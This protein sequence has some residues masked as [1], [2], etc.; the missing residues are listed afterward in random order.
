MK[1]VNKKL[2][3]SQIATICLLIISILL[4]VAYFVV[5]GIA[6]NRAK[7]NT[8]T[9]AS[10][11]Q[12]AIRED[13]GESLYLNRPIAYPRVQESE[14]ILIEI[15]KD[16][17]GYGVSRYPDDNGNF[18][19]H[20]FDGDKEERYPFLPPIAGIEGDFNYE[21]LYA[22]EQNDG[23]G[24]IPHLTYLC[25]ALGAPY[26]TER[27][28]LPEEGTDEYNALLRE[29]GLTSSESTQIVFAYGKRDPATN[30]I[31][32]DTRDS[33][34]ITI[35]GKAVSGAGYYFMVNDGKHDRN[36]IYYTSSE[37]FTYALGGFASFVN[38]R[39][40][41]E[42]LSNDKGFSPYLTTDFKSWTGSLF[43]TDGDVID[44]SKHKDPTIVA[45][46][47]AYIT[48][49]KSQDK[50]TGYNGYDYE[51]DAVLAFDLEALSDVMNATEFKKLKDAFDGVKVGSQAEKIL[52]TLISDL[53]GTSNKYV[54]FTKDENGDVQPVEYKYSISKIESV[55]TTKD[56]KTIEIKD[57]AVQSYHKQLK[58]TYTYTGG[59]KES[60]HEQ[61]AV[62]NINDLP[63]TQRSK[64]VGLD[65][66][67]TLATPVEIT[68]EYTK[69]NALKSNETYYLHQVY[70]VFDENGAVADV[71]TEKS[72]ISYSYVVSVDGNIDVNELNEKDIKTGIVRLCDLKEGDL[73]Y[74]LISLLLN[75]KSEE[76]SEIKDRVVYSKDY[77][78]EFM[79]E[80]SC[81]EISDVEYFVT[82]EIIVSFEFVN[83]SERDPFYGD[84]FFK[85]TLEGEYGMY[86][87]NAGTCEQ[88][89][90]LLGGVGA[91]GS[92]SSG[93][94]GQTVAVGLTPEN[95]YK[96]GLF[97][98][99]VY[100]EM[101][102]G[103]F[104]K[105][106]A[107]GNVE[108]SDDLSDFGW[109]RTVG[110]TLYI[111]D[112]KYDEN[113][114]KYRYIG[115]D[116]YDII[117]R[118]ESDDFD[119]VEYGFVEFWARRSMVMMDVNKLEELKLEFNMKDLKGEY[120]F[121]VSYEEKYEKYVN[122]KYYVSST[123]QEGYSPIQQ[124]II[125]V[126]AGDGAFETEFTK[127]FG[128]G[129]SASL[130]KLYDNT[131][132][133]GKVSYHPGSKLTLGAGYFNSVYQSLLL[134]NYLD[135][136][137]DRIARPGDE[138][139]TSPKIFSM[140]LKVSGKGYYY[141]YDFYRVDARRVMVALYRTDANGNELTNDPVTGEKLGKVSDFYITWGAFQNLA[142]NYITLLNGQPID[143]NAGYYN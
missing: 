5:S 92:N 31:I 109:L 129:V 102:R 128:R 83:A 57:G 78:Y 76:L 59:G 75:K 35:G 103:L 80:F 132:G 62:I 49:Q 65:I 101:P 18:V 2:N 86:G 63:E 47:D 136:F 105:T 50:A 111:S 108:S 54:E 94:T 3:K 12:I 42:G 107:E 134:T 133:G 139:F 60:Y 66:G 121:N 67:E 106:E 23:F 40:V 46:G 44:Y 38:G 141:T 87:L 96:Y 11:T 89:V 52:L 64:F 71:I 33:Y 26:F 72:Y 99:K 7:N 135:C 70:A 114:T 4:T 21:S 37:Y 137:E 61:H 51:K 130:A 122:G 1:A 90:E 34:V 74:S 77:Y 91:Q 85:N 124:E 142:N 97:A 36:C 20:T 19:F 25:S 30:E 123:K 58:V 125:K 98:H 79:R 118:V 93:L 73:L 17:E 81:Y 104:D 48:N 82:N 27:I 138:D 16:G 100:F 39:L 140:R 68:V 53:H 117:A 43:D 45:I 116:M 56:G 119:F 28:S 32:E 41:A 6:K 13:L 131:L 112:A 14:M 113:G 10:T 126:V 22:V 95:M 127:Q 143:K 29:Y 110:F 88:A 55:I 115:S 24:T 120:T 84:T 9:Q 69:A 15:T 8:N